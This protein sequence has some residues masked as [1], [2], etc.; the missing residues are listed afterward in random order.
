[1]NQIRRAAQAQLAQDAPPVRADRLHA[2]RQLG[3]DG[4]HRSAGDNE[5][6]DFVFPFGQATVTGRQLRL[7]Q[8]SDRRRHAVP[9]ARQALYGE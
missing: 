2:Q 4:R 9:A 1:M 7:Q 3:G 5:T 6:Q 8:A